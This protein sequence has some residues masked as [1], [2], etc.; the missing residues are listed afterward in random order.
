MATAPYF[1]GTQPCMKTDPEVFFPE[2]SARPTAEDKRYYAIAVNQAKAICNPCPFI[3]ACLTYALYNDVTGIWGATVDSDRSSIRKIKK[4]PPP[5]P[6]SMVT[7][8]W[9]KQK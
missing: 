3:D 1:D 8:A 2:L 5:K 7:A 9:A 4:I 6:M